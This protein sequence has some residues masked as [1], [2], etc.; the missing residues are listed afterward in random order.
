M[1]GENFGEFGESK[2]IR[3][4]FTHPNLHFKKLWIVDYQKFTGQN[5]HDVYLE[6]LSSF[7]GEARSPMQIPVAH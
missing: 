5:A 4:S 1:A 7:E 3:Q 2:A 6:I